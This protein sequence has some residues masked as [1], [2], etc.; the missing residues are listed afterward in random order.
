MALNPT[1]DHN[2]IVISEAT[3]GDGE[4]KLRIPLSIHGAITYFPCRKPTLH[5]FQG[6][7]PEFCINLLLCLQIRK[8]LCWIL[9]VIFVMIAFQGQGNSQRW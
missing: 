5:E 9:V 7:D 4:V 6:T 2:A 3:P 8:K 1:E